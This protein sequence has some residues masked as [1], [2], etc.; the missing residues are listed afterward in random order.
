MIMRTVLYIATSIDGRIADATGGIAW[1]NPYF[2]EELGFHQFFEKVGTVI[3]GR[4]TYDQVHGFGQWPYAGKRSIVLT[5]RPLPETEHGIESY[6]GRLV[7][8]VPRLKEE[9]PGDIWIVGGAQVGRSF[10][11]A[12]LLDEIEIY[13]A[14]V[15]L[16]QGTTLFGA[17]T[18]RRTLTLLEAK[19][20]TNGVVKMLYKV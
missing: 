18:L 7:E 3:M 17:G 15:I 19:A 16:G 5:S 9:T 14:P 1:L 8:L 4:T 10:L 12:N 6:N 13:V 11:E 20:H 2:S